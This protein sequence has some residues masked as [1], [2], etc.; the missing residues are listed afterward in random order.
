MRDNIGDITF[1]EAYTKTGRILNITV[2]G[3]DANTMPRL[4]NFLTAP[5]VVVWSAVIA[6]CA[7][8]LVFEPQELFVKGTDGQISPIYLQGV[9]FSDGSVSHDLPMP[10]LAQLFNVDN[11]VVSQVNPHLVPFLFH[12][13]VAPV[14]F[15][16]RMFKFLSD[17][18]HLYA[19]TCLVNLRGF[20]LLRGVSILNE[21]LTQRYTGDVTIVPD[22]RVADYMKILSNPTLA[23]I[24]RCAD[25]SE[26]SSWKHISRMQG[27]CAA[28]F[29]IDQ[30]LTHL[31]SQ[32]GQ[33]RSAHALGRVSS[34]QAPRTG[35]RGNG[36][37]Y[38]DQAVANNLHIP[39]TIYSSILDNE[40]FAERDVDEMLSAP[41]ESE[42]S[43]EVDVGRAQ[44]KLEVANAKLDAGDSTNSLHKSMSVA[45]LC[46]DLSNIM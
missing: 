10:R 43:E 3:S 25:E 44:V 46:S 22:I 29:T 21:L 34:F 20:G 11:F 4:L 1:L 30:C 41:N 15:F 33:S 28:E 16:D 18:F 45:D 39:Q 19:T 35:A 14:P 26:R 38:W 37:R 32:I 9:T 27:L 42:P 36:A 13:I 24:R 40:Q 8:P 2:S 6:S 5:N 12:S 23:Y 17:E 31:R 7:I